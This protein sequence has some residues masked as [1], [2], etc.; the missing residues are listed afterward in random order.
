VYMAIQRVI[1]QDYDIDATVMMITAACAVAVNIVLGLTLHGVGGGH[2]HSHSLGGGHG[3]SHDKKPLIENGDR[4]AG[5]N[6]GATQDDHNHDEVVNH[7]HVKKENMN[8]RAAFI[9]V[10]GDF[11]QSI[12]VLIASII[13]YFKP[14][15]KLADP[16]CTFIFSVLVIF[17]TLNI[18]KDAFRVLMEGT[19]QHIDFTEIKDALLSIDGVRYAHNLRI[20]SL[21]TTKITMSV[22]LAID[23]I[24]QSQEILQEASKLMHKRFAIQDSTIQIE[25]YAREMDDCDHC[26]DPVK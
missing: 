26:Q 15:Y 17:S 23:D 24:I 12:G 9:H 7:H 21:T 2:V 20:W 5:H 3:H 11:I 18:L 14:E 13:I 1:N 19:P 22:H 10:I 25:L 4:E 6:Y 16:I 8:V